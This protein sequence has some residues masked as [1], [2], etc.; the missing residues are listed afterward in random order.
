MACLRAK[1]VV[2]ELEREVGDRAIILRADL[3]SDVGEALGDRF[4]VHASPTFLVF[5]ASGRLVH[6]Q[7]GGDVPAARVRALIAGAE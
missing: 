6:Q 4:E 3:L 5:D 2:D 1:P 7:R